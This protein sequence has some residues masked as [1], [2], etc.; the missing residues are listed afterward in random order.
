MR[1]LANARVQASPHVAP[2]RCDIVVDDTGRIAALLAPGDHPPRWSAAVVDDLGGR[3]V[4]PALVDA[5]QHLDKAFSVRDVPNPAGTLEGAIAGYAVHAATLTHAEIVARAER[6]LAACVARGTGAIRSHVNVDPECRLRNVEAVL[7][8]RERWRDR[9][10]IQAV[11]F[12]SGDAPRSPH[13]RDWLDAALAAGCDAIG[14]TP[15]RAPDASAFLDLLFAAGERTGK[16]IDVHL[17]EHL[18][19]AH[20]HFTPLVERTLAAGMQGRVVASHASVLSALAPDAAARVVEALAAAEIGVITLPA[21]NLFLQGRDA[22]S[23]PPRGLTRVNDLARAGVTVACASDSIRDPFVPTGS[24]DML[25]IARWTTLAAHLGSGDLGRAFDMACANPAQLM[26]LGDDHGLRVGAK[27][28]LL[29]TDAE[30]AIDLVAGGALERTVLHA[31]RVVAGPASFSRG[32][33]GS[34]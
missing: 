24:G 15:A 34:A 4:V 14:G 18:D 8:V 32:G 11:A 30:D 21:A 6:S 28:H 13:A 33:A 26:G 27:A 20:L 23:R 17:D 16:P 29:V 3:L 22:A 1:R 7:E 10:D 9:V 5:H 2:A 12:L 25:E 31:G 19:A